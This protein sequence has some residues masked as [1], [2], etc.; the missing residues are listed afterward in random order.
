MSARSHHRWFQFSVRGLLLLI[1]TVAIGLGLWGSKFHRRHQ[2]LKQLRVFMPRA[3]VQYV[4]YEEPPTARWLR[5]QKWLTK[6]V[7][8]DWFDE[9]VEIKALHRAPLIPRTPTPPSESQRCRCS[10]P[11]ISRHT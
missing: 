8:D 10:T 1:T 2:A 3:W 5:R 11:R 7:G 6:L 9:P 4:E